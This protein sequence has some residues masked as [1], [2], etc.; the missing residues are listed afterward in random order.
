MIDAH[1]DKERGAKEELEKK[2]KA[3]RDAADVRGRKVTRHGAVTV[4]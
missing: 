1:A 2:E 3:T 4:V